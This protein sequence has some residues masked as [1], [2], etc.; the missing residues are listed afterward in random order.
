MLWG[1]AKGEKPGIVV[2]LRTA[3]VIMTLL[4][5]VSVAEELIEAA[6]LRTEDGSEEVVVVVAT[7]AT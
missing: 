1:S 2:V 4:D 3:T 5:G 6:E 7:A